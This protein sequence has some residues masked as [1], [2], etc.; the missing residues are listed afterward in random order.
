M[1][2]ALESSPGNSCRRVSDSRVQ[3]GAHDVHG[4]EA[5]APSTAESATKPTLKRR[6]GRL[7]TSPLGSRLG[8]SS[9]R[10]ADM[11]EAGFVATTVQGVPVVIAPAE[12]D[13]ANAALMR[14]ALLRAAAA[15][16]GAITL[17]M[18]ATQFCDSA[19]LSVLIRGH[20][21]AQA[22]GGSLRV[23]T[24]TPQL[25]RILEVTGLHRLLQ[26]FRTLEE[27]LEPPLAQMLPTTIP[28]DKIAKQRGLAGR[29][30]MGR[31]ELARKLGLR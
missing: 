10:W 16:R 13:I 30:K 29:S 14:A 7:G 27:A 25:M 5:A 19:G 11:P 18:T 3:R 26:H 24:S 28:G 2:D 20:Q 6:I 15:G 23:V 17:D 31:D 21:W 9:E 22:K 12:V 8:V 1:L 4:P